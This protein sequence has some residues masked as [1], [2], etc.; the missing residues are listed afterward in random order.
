MSREEQLATALEVLGGEN[1]AAFAFAGEGNAPPYTSVMFFAATPDL[2]VVFGTS[3]GSGKTAY[4]RDGNGVCVQ[5]DTRGVGVEN[6]S[7]FARI[8]LQG[9]LHLAREADEIAALHSVYFEK[10]PFAKPLMDR[11]GVLTFVVEPSRL[12]FAR[13][14]AERF[15]L[16]FS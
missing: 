3:E 1:F 5:V 12:V 13:G 14:F 11:P 7:A 6:M 2:R 16:D 4:A 10:L 9:R 8:T 15:D